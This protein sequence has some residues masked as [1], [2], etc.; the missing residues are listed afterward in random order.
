MKLVPHWING[1][2]VQSKSGRSG[3]VFDPALGVPTKSVGFANQDEINLTIEAAKTAF[4]AWRDTSVTK[5]QQVLFNFR[6]LLNARKGELAEII[7]PSTAR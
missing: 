2:E 4:P 6:E 5:R 7:T 1:S 3:E